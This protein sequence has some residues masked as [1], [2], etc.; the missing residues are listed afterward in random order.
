MK[1][2]YR[3]PRS[4]SYIAEQFQVDRVVRG[5]A[6]GTFNFK[7][8]KGSAV[9]EHQFQ[10]A[11]RIGIGILKGSACSREHQC[12]G[13]VRKGR[14]NRIEHIKKREISRS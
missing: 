12:Q 1:E 10:G 6:V 9:G 2:H 11:E 7:E 14:E 4:T 8:L 5:S 3:Y 13:A